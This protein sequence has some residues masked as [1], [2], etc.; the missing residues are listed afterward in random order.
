MCIYAVVL[1]DHPA[2]VKLGQTKKWKSRRRAYDD[3]NFADGDG[4]LRYRAYTIT[5]EWVDLAGVEQAC[6]ARI[7]KPV[8]RGREWFRGTLDDG[9]KAIE[10][11][12]CEFGLSYIDEGSEESDI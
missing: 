12:L 9:T 1:K 10:A 11:V 7:N 6:L 2:V 3:W 4:V 5:E 8:Y